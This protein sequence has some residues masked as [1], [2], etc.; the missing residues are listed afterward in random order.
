MKLE[1]SKPSKELKPSKCSRVPRANRRSKASNGG[2]DA[3]VATT[4]TGGAR[5]TTGGG[6][7][8]RSRET[9][10]IDGDGMDS[11]VR[12]SS[13]RAGTVKVG[14]FALTDVFYSLADRLVRV[15]SGQP[16]RVQSG[17]GAWLSL[18]LDH[19]SSLSNLKSQ[20]EEIDGIMMCRWTLV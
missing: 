4:R 16:G 14:F 7:V 10:A 20:S 9:M 13:S 5:T 15:L 8:T 18:L 6:C 3:A 2:Q 17:L 11:S 19:S 12:G 1:P